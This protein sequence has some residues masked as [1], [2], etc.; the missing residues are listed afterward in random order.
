MPYKEWLKGPKDLSLIEWDESDTTFAINS[1]GCGYPPR[2]NCTIFAQ[3]F[4]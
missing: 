1:E 2:V 3:Q 4:G